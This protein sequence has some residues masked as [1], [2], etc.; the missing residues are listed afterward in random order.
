MNLSLGL[1][2][3]GL[4]R[5]AWGAKPVLRVLA[6]PGYAEPAVVQ[7][8]ETEHG[9][10][11]ELTLIASDEDLWENLQ[12]HQ[13]QDFD[14]FAANTAEIQRY[15]HANLVRPIDVKA[16]PHMQR[17]LPR[18]Q[19]LKAIPGLF[20]KGDLMALPY[21]YAEMGLI[22]DGQQLAQSPTSYAALWDSRWQGRV[23]MYD[24]GT[25]CFSLAA[26][27]LGWPTPFHLTDRQWPAAVDHLIALRRN[28][29][30][31]YTQPEE[32]V[33]LF[34]NRGAV[35]MFANYGRQQL[36]LLKAAGVDAHYVI[37]KEGA[38]AWLDCWAMTRGARDPALAQAWINHMLGEQAG[39]ALVTQQ[40]LGSTTTVSPDYSEKDKLIWLEPAES[41]ERRNRLWNRIVSGDRASKVLAQ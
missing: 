4:T 14:V 22:Y 9:C 26:I 37:P 3:T 35:L 17:L 13:A 32:S 12:R 15:L 41:E 39:R 7:S 27:N 29:A 25:H 8:F 20:H 30:G 18:F 31:F 34:K 36:Q 16:L 19:N 23:L 11:V 6:W 40:G 2:A 24:G 38:L 5:P 33:A 1:L 21:A 10:R 28:A